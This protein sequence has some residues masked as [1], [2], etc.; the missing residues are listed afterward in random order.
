MQIDLHAA[1][2]SQDAVCT[3][4]ARQQGWGRRSL[5]AASAGVPTA[6][7]TCSVGVPVFTSR[8][9]CRGFCSPAC[10]HCRGPCGCFAQLPLGVSVSPCARQHAMGQGPAAAVHGLE[11]GHQSGTL[12]LRAVPWPTGHMGWDSRIWGS[13][14][15]W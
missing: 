9:F 10:M 11:V 15:A 2:P 4:W 7:H 1:T 8:G 14:T 13:P 3:V 6:P 5:C 12:G